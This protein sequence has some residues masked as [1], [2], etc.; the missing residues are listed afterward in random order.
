MHSSCLLHGAFTQRWV[1]GEEGTLEG[2][3]RGD[4]G[5]KERVKRRGG[6]ETS[7]VIYESSFFLLFAPIYHLPPLDIE[8]CILVYVFF[9]RY[10]FV[11]K[12]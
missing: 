4:G 11:G 1:K 2:K 10:R 6:E 5:G 3:E 9:Q 12:I 8:R 7:Q